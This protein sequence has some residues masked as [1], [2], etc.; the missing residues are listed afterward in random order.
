MVIAAWWLQQSQ[1]QQP[2]HAHRIE[3]ANTRPMIMWSNAASRNS[4]QV[5]V[6]WWRHIYGCARNNGSIASDGPQTPDTRTEPGLTWTAAEAVVS[7]RADRTVTEQT[8]PIIET[9]IVHQCRVRRA[10]SNQGAA[11]T[12]RVWITFDITCTCTYIPAAVC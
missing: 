11:P 10:I 8:L 2:T 9:H 3:P 7:G 1:L 4:C 5:P 12:L 6:T